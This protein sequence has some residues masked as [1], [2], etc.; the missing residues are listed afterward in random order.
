M[1]KRK[2]SSDPVQR[3]RSSFGAMWRRCTDDKIRAWK[4]YGGRGIK[5]CDRWRSFDNFVADMGLRP[6]GTSIDRYPNN[7]GNYE[8]GNCRWATPKQQSYFRIGMPGL[9]VQRAFLEGGKRYWRHRAARFK[10]EEYGTLYTLLDEQNLEYEIREAI[11]NDVGFF[12][13]S[14]IRPQ[15]ISYCGDGE[16]HAGSDVE[17]LTL[18]QIGRALGVT[19][20][21]VRQIEEVALGKLRSAL[22][23]I[24]EG[25]GIRLLSSG[26]ASA[27]RRKAL[28]RSVVRKSKRKAA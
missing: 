19:R 17:A 10:W 20:E 9:P 5:V 25:R 13:A 15:D 4:R 22:G 21:R 24:E 23:A 7:D 8:P 12:P 26:T 28:G 6:S 11:A 27:L 16:T 18:E 2:E 3:T 1:R 14:P